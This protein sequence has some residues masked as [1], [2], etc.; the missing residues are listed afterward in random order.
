MSSP[1]RNFHLPLPQDTYERLKAEADR[2]S[3][4]AT[5]VARHAIEEWLRERRR[6]FLREEIAEYAAKAAGT[7]DDLD[8]QLEKAAVS[9]L[10]G[11][12]AKGK[13][14]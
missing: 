1:L 7:T 4:P 2:E 6:L 10:L 11:G 13:R 3:R 9:N 12:R 5:V 14:R 8:P